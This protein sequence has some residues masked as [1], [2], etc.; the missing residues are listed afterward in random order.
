MAVAVCLLPFMTAGGA[1]CVLF[2]FSFWLGLEW[3]WAS[4]IYVHGIHSLRSILVGWISSGRLFGSFQGYS[5][6]VWNSSKSTT[7][8]WLPISQHNLPLPFTSFVNCTV[9]P[10]ATVDDWISF[11]MSFIELL[12]VQ[13]CFLLINPKKRLVRSKFSVPHQYQWKCNS[14]IQSLMSRQRSDHENVFTSSYTVATMQWQMC[15]M[16]S[17]V[18]KKM[19]YNILTVALGPF[20]GSQSSS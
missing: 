3:M 12:R 10:P 6:N 18:A 13:R 16:D 17:M 11:T 19:I 8:E 4:N 2:I 5:N 15:L 9:F 1:K 20:P 14:I 7:Q